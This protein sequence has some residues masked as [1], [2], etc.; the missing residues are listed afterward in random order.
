MKHMEIYKDRNFGPYMASFTTE[1]D[2]A[3]IV[4][5]IESK[6]DLDP[7]KRDAVY[8]RKD[9]I[10]NFTIS[11]GLFV[12]IARVANNDQER[13]LLGNKEQRI[14]AVAGAYLLNLSDEGSSIRMPTEMAKNR[15]H[16]KGILVEMGTGLGIPNNDLPNADGKLP[17]RCFARFLASAVAM[18]VFRLAGKEVGGREFNFDKLVCN[19]QNRK[20]MNPIRNWLVSL[21]WEMIECPSQQLIESSSVT[22]IDR[23]DFLNRDKLFFELATAKLPLSAKYLLD[24]YSKSALVSD[25]AYDSHKVR[26]DIN[27]GDEMLN[28]LKMVRESSQVRNSD[29]GYTDLR[30]RLYLPEPIAPHSNG[31]NGNGHRKTTLGNPAIQPSYPAQTATP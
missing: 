15:G 10:L 14:V 26:I 1:K 21:A 23:S 6:K 27:F 17:K 25:H 5:L 30:R 19:V 9:K 18:N 3:E 13:E 16:E 7:S 28:L 24:C 29:A 22:T 12:K 2:V 11:N 4:A 8:R 20:Q 31:Y